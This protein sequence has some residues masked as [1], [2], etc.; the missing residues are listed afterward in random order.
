VTLYDGNIQ[1]FQVNFEKFPRK[2]QT[3]I[4]RLIMG[5]LATF[6]SPPLLFLRKIKA[7]L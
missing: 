4:T 7:A 2:I 6:F 3:L 5:T 1:L